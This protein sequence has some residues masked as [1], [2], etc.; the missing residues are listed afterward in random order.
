[1]AFSMAMDKGNMWI[2]HLYKK[3][4]ERASC[5]CPG[6]TDDEFARKFMVPSLINYLSGPAGSTAPDVDWSVD[7]ATC[8]DGISLRN[9]FAK[10]MFGMDSNEG[11][12][13][14]EEH[15]LPTSCTWATYMTDGCKVNMTHKTGAP[16]LDVMVAAKQCGAM[17]DNIFNT[18]VSITIGGF[19]EEVFKPCAATGE[20]TCG[21]DL[22]CVNLGTE[23]VFGIV[24]FED[25]GAQPSDFDQDFYKAAL[26]LGVYEATT[27]PSPGCYPFSSMVADFRS[28]FQSWFPSSKVAADSSFSFCVPDVSIFEPSSLE[29]MFELMYGCSATSKSKPFYNLLNDKTF[30]TTQGGVKSYWSTACTGMGVWDGSLYSGNVFASDRMDGSFFGDPVVAPPINTAEK[31]LPLFTWDCLWTM[32]MRLTDKLGGAFRVTGFREVFQLFASRIGTVAE[33]RADVRT[34]GFTVMRQHIMDSYALYTP[35]WLI[36]AFTNQHVDRAYTITTTWENAWNGKQVTLVSPWSKLIAVVQNVIDDVPENKL[37]LTDITSCSAKNYANDGCSMSYTGLK[38]VF[39]T[40]SALNI[41]MAMKQC[42]AF[43]SGLPPPQGGFAVQN[44]AVLSL[45][46]LKAC[47][48]NSDC[49]S[50]STCQDLTSGVNDVDFPDLFGEMVKGTGTCHSSAGQNRFVRDMILYL[51]G[52]A[53]GSDTKF[54]F[55]VPQLN[56]PDTSVFE[57]L[58]KQTDTGVK[59]AKLVSFTGLIPG[60]GDKPSVNIVFPPS[61]SARY[62]LRKGTSRL[63]SWVS[64]NTPTGTKVTIYI[65]KQSDM[66]STRV[67]D[68]IENKNMYTYDVPDDLGTVNYLIKICLV[69]YGGSPCFESGIF[70]VAEANPDAQP[71]VEA[72]QVLAADMEQLGEGTPERALFLVTAKGLIA[73]VLKIESFRVEPYNVVGLNR[74]D[75]G[76]VEVQF[77]LLPDD[78]GRDNTSPADLQTTLN[79]PEIQSTLAAVAAEDLQMNS[80]ATGGGLSAPTANEMNNTMAE[81]KA[82]LASNGVALIVGLAVGGV[83]LLLCAAGVGVFVYMQRQKHAVPAINAA[84]TADKWEAPPIDVTPESTEPGST[85]VTGGAEDQNV[86]V[87]TPGEA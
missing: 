82:L 61:S 19:A 46:P 26:D 77:R 1:M 27:D 12:A 76:A 70:T 28:G 44:D 53:T 39:D 59:V 22:K 33:C 86:G 38:E 69:E 63:L 80:G 68:K 72:T 9:L 64:L 20:A 42:P 71:A 79:S 14:W 50:G 60:I 73:K 81:G 48:I 47:S 66:T 87:E 58:F 84:P 40:A 35:K 41:I 7:S 11:E 67:A 75:M 23:E 83:C 55:C 17:S 18:Y 6:M 32:A 74:R 51:T 54:A 5:A 4:K 78:T 45:S 16:A 34:K 36:E 8:Y 30:N 2:N 62:I 24:P 21:E 49:G 25:L 29:N 15:I 3:L 85:Q 10:D 65:V 13:R 57:T 56:L 52:S 37:D 31:I 43:D